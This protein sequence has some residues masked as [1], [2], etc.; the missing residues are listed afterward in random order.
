MTHA[1]NFRKYLD[2]S[3]DQLDISI[4]AA[5]KYL[6]S[7]SKIDT[8]LSSDVSVEHKTDGVKLTIIK[9]A[10][11]GHLSDYI[12]AYKGNILYS[13]EFDYQPNVKIKDESIG[14]SQFKAVFTHFTKLSKNNIPVGTE[15]FV[16]FLMKKPTLSSNY[17]T[18]HKMVLIGYSNSSWEEKFGKLLTKNNGM[19]TDKRDV[20]AQ[21][22]KIDTPALLFNGVLG[23]K[24]TFERGIISNK[25][26]KEYNIQKASFS[27]DNQEILLDD[28]RQLFLSIESKYGGK[29]EGVV[30]K[31]GSIILKWQQEYQ[32]DQDAR[33]QNKMKYRENDPVDEG[34]YWESVKRV[35]LEIANGITANSRKIDD[36]MSELST[37][38]KRLKVD[39]THSKKTLANIKDDI[40]LTAKTQILKQLRGNNNALV[41]GKFRV[42]T[43]EGH[44]KLFKSASKIYD[45]LVIC[46]VTSKDTK[47]TKD[48][49]EKMIRAVAPNAIIM[50]SP[51]GNLSKIIN[52]SPVNINAVYAGTDR[53]LDYQK[54]LNSMLG[55]NVKEIQ[56]TDSDISATSVID[57]IDDEVYFKANT[58]TTIHKMYD[59]IK[60][61]Y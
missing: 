4:Q 51:N 9:K 28:L 53:A 22:L 6:N 43:K 3:K 47:D 19:Q 17:S 18:K 27:W 38:M 8:F 1:L 39:I 29:E 16:E 41:I 10:D 5:G 54:Q 35:A 60:S 23:T 59:E 2:E 48:L 61:A 58:P 11:K 45:N 49:R 26:K 32:L 50:H 36:L 52:S 33:L 57:N 25:L 24:E 42:V 56:R 46:I 44:E 37:T 31:Y 15:L 30:I 40:Q 21:E 7:S 55:V 14:A 12:F 13:T 34:N 20:Y